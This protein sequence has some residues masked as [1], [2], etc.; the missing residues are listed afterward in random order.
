MEGTS[1]IDPSVYPI[2]GDGAWL[3]P[4]G[5]PVF[6][7]EPARPL[8]GVFVADPTTFFTETI[9]VD[10]WFQPASEPVWTVASR[11]PG[12]WA[13]VLE[14]TLFIVPTMDTWWQAAS[15]PVRV[16]LPVIP[17]LAEIVLEPTIYVTVGL[18]TWFQPLSE[19]VLPWPP[20]PH[21][22]CV[23]QGSPDDFVDAAVV[24]AGPEYTVPESRMHYTVPESQP[25]YA[26]PGGRL[27]YTIPDED[28]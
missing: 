27:H 15:E 13:G 9:T 22:G 8:V 2:P 4:I 16:A 21:G 25:H 11:L 6:L 10:K 7:R 14:S 1:P 5:R 17:G 19:P 26:V 3:Q 20:R 24:V 23:Y 28:N 12:Y 18:D